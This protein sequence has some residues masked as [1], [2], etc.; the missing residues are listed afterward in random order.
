MLRNKIS[1]SFLR[2]AIRKGS[3]SVKMTVMVLSMRR[4]RRSSIG[5]LGRT[6]ALA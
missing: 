3:L 4:K 5:A 6:P 2:L 1:G